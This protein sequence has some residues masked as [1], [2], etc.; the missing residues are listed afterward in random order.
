[1]TTTTTGKKMCMELMIYEDEIEEL[2]IYCDNNFAV[3]EIIT[4]EEDYDNPEAV[5]VAEYIFSCIYNAYY[6][7]SGYY[8]PKIELWPD[9]YEYVWDFVETHKR[10]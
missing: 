9:E 5:R 6:M 3:R 4:C 8:L 2:G 7:G 1:M 10:L